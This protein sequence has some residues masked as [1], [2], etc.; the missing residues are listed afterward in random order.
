MICWP[1]VDLS[2]ERGDSLAKCQLWY[3]LWQLF[4][5]SCLSEFVYYSLLLLATLY[6]GLALVFT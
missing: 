1:V 3:A 5:E 4:E 6:K 2:D